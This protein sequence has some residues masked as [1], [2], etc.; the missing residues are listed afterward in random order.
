[1]GDFRTL[2]NRVLS[3]LT[4]RVTVGWVSVARL[5]GWREWEGFPRVDS[6]ILVNRKRGT[7][8]PAFVIC[9]YFAS[10]DFIGFY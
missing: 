8:W 10:G 3:T 6:T 1:M 5:S 9:S 2:S 7:G 4:G